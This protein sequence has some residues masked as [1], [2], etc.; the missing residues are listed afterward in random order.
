MSFPH[1]TSS[2]KAAKAAFERQDFTTTAQVY[3]ELAKLEREPEVLSKFLSNRA[4][5][6]MRLARAPE[7]EELCRRAITCNGNNL[8]AHKIRA[9]ALRRM[10]K[11]RDSQPNCVYEEV[12]R[13]RKEESDNTP[14]VFTVLFA[15]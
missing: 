1:L 9:A 15:L 11:G 12:S 10:A 14:C 4:N 3:E 8:N 5:C 2:D 13:R 7:A 6:L